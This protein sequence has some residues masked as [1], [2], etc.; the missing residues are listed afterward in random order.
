MKKQEIR[1][2]YGRVIGTIETDDWTG[3][4]TARDFY[5]RV[6]GTWEKRLD[7]TRDF[8]GRVVA[9]G[10]ALSGLIIEEEN[11]NHNVDVSKKVK[12]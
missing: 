1:D 12:K 2:F 6:L 7:V 9:R 10:D 11:K 5:G 8:Y 4:K 3:N